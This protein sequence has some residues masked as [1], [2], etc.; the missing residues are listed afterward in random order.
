MPEL[1]WKSGE[2]FGYDA[3]V[4]GRTAPLKTIYLK[5]SPKLPMPLPTTPRIKKASAHISQNENLI[6][7][8]SRPGGRAYHLPPSDVPEVDP[9]G[10]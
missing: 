6:F 10:L 9:T 7:E 8:N 4:A 5:A 2:A 3:S 1:Q